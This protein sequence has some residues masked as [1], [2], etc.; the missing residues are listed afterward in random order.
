[1]RLANR[2][3]AQL[4]QQQHTKQAT[5]TKK[6]NA[7]R[8]LDG[9]FVPKV[10]VVIILVVLGVRLLE[11]SLFFL[12]GPQVLPRAPPR[13]RVFV[14]GADAVALA[15]RA[16]DALVEEDSQF[17]AIGRGASRK[18]RPQAAPSEERASNGFGAFFWVQIYVRAVEPARL[19]QS[20]GA[21]PVSSYPCNPAH[22]LGLV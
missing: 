22:R 18:G 7:A 1:M 4:P 3:A 13:A 12:L 9:I 21:L 2:R 14:V 11:A 20:Q 19:R 5:T 17:P 6:I 8:V 10:V 15:A 16:G